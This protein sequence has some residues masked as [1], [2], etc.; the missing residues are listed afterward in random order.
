LLPV[1]PPLS[2]QGSRASGGPRNPRFPGTKPPVSLFFVL[3]PGPSLD[4]W[5]LRKTRALLMDV[6]RRPIGTLFASVSDPYKYGL[7]PRPGRGA[8]VLRPPPPSAFP[9]APPSPCSPLG[10][11]GSFSRWSG[12]RCT[13]FDLSSFFPGSR[14]QSVAPTV[15]LDRCN[16]VN[17]ASCMD[18]GPG[19]KP[20]LSSPRFPWSIQFRFTPEPVSQWPLGPQTSPVGASQGC[21]PPSQFPFCRVTPGF[22]PPGAA[23]SFFGCGRNGLLP[24][25]CPFPSV[26][27]CPMKV[28]FY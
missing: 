15:P 18:G 9:F 5:E 3:S 2:V 7:H 12:F 10:D 20:F 8:P 21:D 25:F 22:A 4:P 11:L 27:S 13:G 23:F 28:V 14:P 17:P 6:L 1:T 24:S 16:R 26:F 19:R